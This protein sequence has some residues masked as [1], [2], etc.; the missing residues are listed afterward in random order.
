MGKIRKPGCVQEFAAGG[1]VVQSRQGGRGEYA[2]PGGLALRP[3]VENGL[4]TV[5]GPMRRADYRSQTPGG[6][7]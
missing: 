1:A 2:F 3:V 7:Q 4:D 5:S 6:E